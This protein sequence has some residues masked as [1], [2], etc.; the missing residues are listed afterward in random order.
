MLKN[1]LKTLVEPE[2]SKYC[3]LDGHKGT[4]RTVE[5]LRNKVPAYCKVHVGN[6]KSPATFA[7]TLS[8]QQ[9]LEVYLSTTHKFP[10]AGIVPD[11]LYEQR[12]LFQSEE[13]LKSQE[14]KQ[15]K[16]YYE[17]VPKLSDIGKKPT[18]EDNFIQD[19]TRPQSPTFCHKFKFDALPSYSDFFG[20]NDTIYLCFVSSSG[21]KFQIKCEFSK[22]EIN[23]IFRSI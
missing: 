3:I 10:G 7:I 11:V 12:F 20:L 9:D 6:Q 2:A 1:S 22:S 17:N 13:M 19:N 21:G 5:T 18:L 16:K 23:P 14:V 4:S 15:K 8:R